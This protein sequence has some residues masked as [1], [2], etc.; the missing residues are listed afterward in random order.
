MPGPS[1]SAETESQ[2]EPEP[3]PGPGP[4]PEA[5]AWRLARHPRSVGRVRTAFRAQAEAWELPEESV[6]TAVLLLSELVTNAVRYARVRGRQIE[7]R[8]VREEAALRV[9]VSDAGLG[10]PVVRAADDEQETG[11]GLAL[12][13]V[14]ADDRGVTPRAHGIGK[15]VWFTCGHAATA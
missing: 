15:T 3:E 14:L 6:E 7:V 12:V 2:P 8:C 9:E 1:T 5:V 10:M 11:R 13:E 4:E